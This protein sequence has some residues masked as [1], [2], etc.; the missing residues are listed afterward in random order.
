MNVE[1]RWGYVVHKLAFWRHER[2]AIDMH[3]G[4]DDITLAFA[5]D[6][7][8]RTGLVGVEAQSATSTVRLRSGLVLAAAPVAAQMPRVALTPGLKPVQQL[9]RTLCEIDARFGALRRDRVEQELEYPGDGSA[10]CR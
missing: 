4:I 7:W 9:D 3:D 2:R 1:R 10:S 5:A 6:A 8:S